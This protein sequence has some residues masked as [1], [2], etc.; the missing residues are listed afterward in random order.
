[1]LHYEA[2]QVGIK[3]PTRAKDWWGTP[4]AGAWRGTDSARH[5]ATV[6]CACHSSQWAIGT[7]YM[8]RNG[9]GALEH[10][11]HK[12]MGSFHNASASWRKNAAAPGSL[13][14]HT[15]A[16]G[17]GLG[18][19]AALPCRVRLA[20]LP[21]LRSRSTPLSM[22][23]HS[24]YVDGWQLCVHS[25]GMCVSHNPT[26]AFQ[27]ARCASARRPT[28]G[29][30]ATFQVPPARA[31]GSPRPQAACGSHCLALKLPAGSNSRTLE[32]PEG[33]GARACWEGAAP[34]L[35]A[36]EWSQWLPGY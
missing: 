2:G 28:S 16:A 34:A 14:H 30:A 6:P 7:V 18:A 13:C 19:R 26:L 17:P 5:G 25:P 24:W 32:P 11:D 35:A 20:G 4:T 36:A 9:G 31:T 3:F 29:A 10:R 23:N 12:F 8:H 1:M 21:S 33:F 27:V 15:P 22:Y